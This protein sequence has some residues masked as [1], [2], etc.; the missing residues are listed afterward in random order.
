[1]KKTGT[2]KAPAVEIKDEVIEDLCGTVEDSVVEIS[3][4]D[5]INQLRG[6]PKTFLKQ[7][8]KKANKKPTD[9][10]NTKKEVAAETSPKAT[11]KKRKKLESPPVKNFDFTPRSEEEISRYSSQIGLL[12]RTC[13][14][15]SEQK[16]Q[17]IGTQLFL[18]DSFNCQPCQFMCFSIPHHEVGI[19]NRSHPSAP[20]P[21]SSDK[22]YGAFTG[23]STLIAFL[24]HNIG[25]TKDDII[26]KNVAQYYG[27]NSRI[28][29][30]FDKNNELER[31]VDWRCLGGDKNPIITSQDQKSEK[32]VKNTWYY[33]AP[34]RDDE[35]LLEK[36]IPATKFI[37]RLNMEALIEAYEYPKQFG[38]GIDLG[39]YSIVDYMEAKENLKKEK[40]GFNT[41]KRLVQDFVK[42]KNDPEYIE[43]I[44][45]MVISEKDSTNT[46]KRSRGSTETTP[47]KE[48]GMTLEL[49][50]SKI[51]D[52]IS[53]NSSVDYFNNDFSPPESDTS[54]SEDDEPV[55]K[56]KLLE[57]SIEE[58]LA[59]GD[60]AFEHINFSDEE[61]EVVPKKKPS[62]KPI[63]KRSPLPTNS[64]PTV[65]KTTPVRKF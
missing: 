37:N 52:R 6:M 4:E 35:V 16:P 33:Y 41:S 1:M 21:V 17:L 56:Q 45:N 57:E 23:L 13:G 46:K 26:V 31:V 48:Q 36:K 5:M 44:Y 2:K 34:S 15:L 63:K 14:T 7:L 39:Y 8:L 64:S 51:S 49:L 10:S 18:L 28:D 59:E 43:K 53:T 12:T 40:D 61:V 29:V 47:T 11:E 22:F 9:N 65:K 3:E 54:S 55:K 30:I 42:S 20:V 50:L 38:S 25:C 32:G 62:P 27:V 24:K 58:I 19:P 60:A